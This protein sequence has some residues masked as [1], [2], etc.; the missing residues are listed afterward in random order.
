MNADSPAAARPAPREHHA[1]LGLLAVQAVLFLSLPLLGSRHA[2]TALSSFP[3]EIA[4]DLLGAGGSPFDGYD[5][6]AAGPLLWAAVEAP[7]LALL[8]RVGLVQVLA[9]L[10]VALGATAASWA[11]ARETM[12]RW[13]AFAVAALV[14]LPPP[15][16]WV[17]QHYGAYHVLPLLTAPLGV[18][19]LHRARG[20]VAQLLG[21]AVLGSSVAWSLGAIAVAAPLSLAW[22]VDRWR[23]GDRAALGLL[24]AGAAVAALPL[25]YKVLLHQ[26]WDGLAPPDATLKATKPFV[27]ALGG[28]RNPVVELASMVFVQLPYGLHYGLHGLRGGGVLWAAVAGLAWLFAA[29]RPGPRPGGA[30]LLVPPSVV[31]VGLVTGWFV[32]H[33]G[34]AVPFERDARHIVGLTQGLAFAVGAALDGVRGR[35]RQTL[36]GLVVLLLA[37]SAFTTVRAAAL[38]WSEGARPS[39]STEFR[40][41]SRYVSGFF[42]GPHFLADSAPAAASCA[43]LSPPLDADCRRGVAMAF[44]YGRSPEE[45]RAACAA[46]EAATDEVVTPWCWLGHGWGHTHRSWREPGW[47]EQRCRV[48][49]DDA[50]APC[51]RGVGWGLAQDFGDRPGVL[52][53][54]IGGLPSASRRDL[55]EGVGIYAGMVARTRE[56]GARICRRLV[57]DPQ[58]AR[59][60]AG[61]DGNDGFM[62]P[63]E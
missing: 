8:G 43:P 20:R 22:L 54:W 27:L 7:F 49:D 39:L 42:R 41:E 13:P 19:M 56:H 31:L 16:T 52:P 1:L 53:A 46:I 60:L 6:I 4:A 32:F 59:C 44:G 37:S 25:L 48:L 47:A 40:L 35:A 21:V 18:W 34:D 26:P 58:L 51:L 61:L 57:P 28:G 2:W 24:A 23:R 11:C 29:L 38:A 30:W 62:A 45:A 14:A 33:P 50:R 9:T 36:G 5:G 10:L 17:H 12:G 3:A 63:L 15:N 55:A